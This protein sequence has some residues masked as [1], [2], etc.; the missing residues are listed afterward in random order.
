MYGLNPFYV[1]YLDILYLQLKPRDKKRLK[2]NI[3]IP[4]YLA[5]VF[6]RAMESEVFCNAT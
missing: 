5:F 6:Y 3:F 1:V 2:V 4:F